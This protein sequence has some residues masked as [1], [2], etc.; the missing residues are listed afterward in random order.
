MGRVKTYEAIV[1]GEDVIQPG[2]PESFHV[3]LKEL[4][5]LGLSVELLHEETE[6]L[7]L[8]MAEGG[9]EERSLSAEGLPSLQVIEGMAQPIPVVIG[10]PGDD[11]PAVV[12]IDGGP[13]EAS[14]TVPTEGGEDGG[15][16]AVANQW[17][18]RTRGHGSAWHRQ[19]GRACTRRRRP[20]RRWRGGGRRGERQLEAHRAH[21]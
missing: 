2:I 18:R 15:G 16:P 4:Q 17:R 8:Q 10:P 14:D 6:H 3:L 5:S 9:L 12:P 1:K 13:G 21:P 19:R 7:S 20:K 11:L